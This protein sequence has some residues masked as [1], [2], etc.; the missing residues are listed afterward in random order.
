MGI[1]PSSASRPRLLALA[2]NLSLA[3]AFQEQ[4]GQRALPAQRALL[5][6]L[7]LPAI[8]VD[9]QD[10]LGLRENLVK[11]VQWGLQDLQAPLATPGLLEKLVVLAHLGLPARRT[12]SSRIIL[13]SMPSPA[14]RLP[15]RYSLRSVTVAR[16]RQPSSSLRWK[17]EHSSGSNPLTEKRNWSL[18]CAKA[19]RSGSPRTRRNGP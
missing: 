1:V 18:V 10:R 6:L 15:S 4:Q 11:Q 3:Q 19:T 13:E 2:K 16:S 12:R 14:L 5:A 7:V 8:L 17:K 9:L